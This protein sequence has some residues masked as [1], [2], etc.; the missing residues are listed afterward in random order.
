MSLDPAI[1]ILDGH[2]S[3]IHACLQ[4]STLKNL[5]FCRLWVATDQPWFRVGEG[6]LQES[7]RPAPWSCGFRPYYV[8]QFFIHILER[9]IELSRHDPLDLVWQFLALA[10][11]YILYIYI[12][13]Y[14][15][16]NHNRNTY[17]NDWILQPHRDQ[18]TR[19]HHGSL[20]HARVSFNSPYIIPPPSF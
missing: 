12:Y 5:H 1:T 18:P 7:L 14:K 4:G 19:C 9:C 16:L 15:L 3:Y 8:N 10:G 2:T 20:H 17:S 11:V 13:I 6:C